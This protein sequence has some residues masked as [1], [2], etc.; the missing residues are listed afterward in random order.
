MRVLACPLRGERNVRVRAELSTRREG[1]H[2][3]SM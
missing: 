2:V 1:N 3:E